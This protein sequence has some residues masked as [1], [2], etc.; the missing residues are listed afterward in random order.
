MADDL[1]EG[2]SNMGIS[3]DTVHVRL[4]PVASFS[5]QVPAD[6]YNSEEISSPPTHLIGLIEFQQLD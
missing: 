5:T 6:V 2:P 4:I 1:Q 3:L